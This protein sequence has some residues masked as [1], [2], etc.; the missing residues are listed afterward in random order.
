MQVEYS[1]AAISLCLPSP[2]VCRSQPQPQLQIFRAR[3][4]HPRHSQKHQRLSSGNTH[5]RKN[6]VGRWPF[7][8]TRFPG[9]PGD[10]TSR[11]YDRFPTAR[12]GQR[13]PVAACPGCTLPSPHPRRKCPPSSV[14]VTVAENSTYSATPVSRRVRVCLHCWPPTLDTKQSLPQGSYFQHRPGDNKAGQTVSDS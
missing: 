7:S 8:V 14:F 12:L 6:L 13:P 2:I 5:K 11:G 1:L 3:A 10:L 4:R 9:W